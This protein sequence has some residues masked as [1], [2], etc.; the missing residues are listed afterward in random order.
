[1]ST[2]KRVRLAVLFLIAAAFFVATPALAATNAKLTPTGVEPSASG[3]ARLAETTGFPPHFYGHL[4]VSCRGLT[5]G[6]TYYFWAAGSLYL[7][8][9]TASAT[10]TGKADGWIYFSWLGFPVGVMNANGDD[11]LTGK[12]Q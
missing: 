1:M 6:A 3:Q 4:S 5:P 7:W 9:F 8:P 10:G 2:M 11:V 12:V